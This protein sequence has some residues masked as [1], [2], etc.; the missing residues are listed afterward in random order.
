MS[1]KGFGSEQHDLALNATTPT[2]AINKVRKEGLD[3]PTLGSEDG[4]AWFLQPLAV[5][6]LVAIKSF[7]DLVYVP[8]HFRRFHLF[9]KWF[10]QALFVNSQTVFWKLQPELRCCTGNSLAAL[11]VP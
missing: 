10:K 8:I 3:P 9:V 1:Y 5:R 7:V 2:V 4:P 6:I 11:P